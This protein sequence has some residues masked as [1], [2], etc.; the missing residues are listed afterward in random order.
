M[1]ITSLDA[2]NESAPMDKNAPFIAKV[3][4]GGAKS[5]KPAILTRILLLKLSGILLSC[6]VM[7]GGSVQAQGRAATRIQARK[8]GAPWC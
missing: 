2:T 1:E 3:S 6:P 5:S 7:Q 8:K 4:A